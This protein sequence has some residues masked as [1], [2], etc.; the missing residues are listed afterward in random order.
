MDEVE[1]NINNEEENQKS[2]LNEPKKNNR[3]MSSS[4]KVLASGILKRKTKKSHTLIER[5]GIVKSSNSI[6]WD[7]KAID[8][9]KN[10]RKKHPMDKE[11]LKK[12]K[13]KFSNSIPHN[14]EDV[15]TKELEKVNKL[16]KNDDVFSKVINA[17]NDGKL[18]KVK[19]NNSCFAFGKFQRKFN[20]REFYQATE[21]EKI[22]DE[23]L[24]QEQKLT[25][26]NTLY[27]KMLKDVSVE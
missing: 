8:E 17:L 7:N 11:K 14:E 26:Q 21:K 24:G 20:M 16:N 10:Y 6:K 27:N 5:E 3:K 1:N 19:R 22:F 25:L 4:R 15:Y 23:S 2:N 12:S 9:Q 13:S 18:K